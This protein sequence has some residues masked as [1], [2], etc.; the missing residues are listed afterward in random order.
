M[1]L[2]LKDKARRFIPQQ[3]RLLLQLR[4]QPGAGQAGRHLRGPHGANQLRSPTLRGAGLDRPAAR[5]LGGT[6]P[7]P[8]RAGRAG[9]LKPMA[10]FAGRP[11]AFRSRG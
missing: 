6:S 9:E 3:P 11:T 4:R 5:A 2:N 7:R 8:T 1:L 10:G